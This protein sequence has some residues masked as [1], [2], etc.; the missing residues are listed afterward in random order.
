MHINFQT[1]VHPPVEKTEQQ[2]GNR[3]LN[4]YGA[5]KM[6][7][8]NPSGVVMDLD[9]NRTHGFKGISAD[10]KKD[11]ERG[12]IP[13][14]VMSYDAKN[15]H[16]YM[17]VMS[18]TMSAKDFQELK[19]EGYKPGKMSEAEAVTG[20]DRIKVILAQSGVDVAGF[21]D[22]LDKETVKEITG[23]YAGAEGL[24]GESTV[25]ELMSADEESLKD[26]VSKSLEE[27]DLPATEAN[28]KDALTALNMA[29][30]LEAPDS[31]STEYLLSNLKEPT[32]ENVYFAEHS[33]AGEGSGQAGG[34]FSSDGSA[35]YAEVA[36]NEDLEGLRDQI[37]SVLKRAGFEPDNRLRNDAEYLIRSGF[38]L[39][40][41]T[42]GLYEDIKGIAFPLKAGD[43]MAEISSAISGG[44]GAASAALIRGYNRIKSERILNETRLQMNTEAN[45]AIKTDSGFSLET[46]S[47]SEKVEELK[48]KEDAFYR[49]AFL[50]G[51][52]EG[53]MSLEDCISLAEETS[54]K[55]NEIKNMPAALAGSFA[56][57]E[58]F[59]VNDVYEAGNLMKAKFEEAGT[60][61]EAVGTE[62]R[63]DLG[64][65][66]GDAFR[67]AADLLKEL[68]IKDT[69]ENLRAVRILGYNGMEITGENIDSVKAADQTVRTL[70]NR[71][72]GS[73]VVSLIREGVNPLETSVQDLI[74]KISDMEN[75][76]EENEKF[77][78][79]LF[80]LERN[81]EISDEE[82]ESYIG[83]F[84]LIR[85]IEKSDGAVIGAVVNS[86]RE[87]S[88]RNLLTELRTRGRGHMDFSIDDDFGGVEASG[89]T[90][91]IGK[92][93]TQ[94]E[95]AFRKEPGERDNNESAGEDK[96]KESR[97]EE[98]V[99]YGEN[100]IHEIYDRLD[101]GA[102]KEMG[103]LSGDTT[104][105]ELINALRKGSL[106]EAQQEEM[107]SE[108]MLDE[109]REAASK[110]DEVYEALLRFG[111]EIT[112]ENV[113]AMDALMNSRGA[114]F[115][116]FAELF[117][118]N[119][120]DI[121][122]SAS[123]KILDRM[124]RDED[125]EEGDT[126]EE[127]REAYGEMAEEAASVLKEASE[128]ADSYIDLKRLHNLNRQLTVARALSNEENY[129]IPM[130]LDGKFTSVN[131]KII[132]GTGE[133]KA[134]VS[135]ESE[136]YGK[137]Y[138]E[139]TLENGSV[140]GFVTT[141]GDEGESP[142]RERTELFKQNLGN[143]GIDAGEII[144]EKSLKTDINR[145]PKIADK[146]TVDHR[147]RPSGTDGQENG[148][149]KDAGTDPVLLY[150]TAGI[151]I[152]SF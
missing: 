68:E 120:P 32:I 106:T 50:K 90:A 81:R 82:A 21:T 25:Q 6:S 8:M 60:L 4:A 140:N 89:E 69:I 45:R 132:R 56:S 30:D 112:P 150:K 116:A 55:V 114:L 80:K 28:V 18:N 14:D 144:F 37:D 75:L 117:A 101:P 79:Y 49:A 86:G 107:Y 61:Y 134:S 2:A 129:E 142:V 83:I 92:I 119:M 24:S 73:A 27:R 135:F 62:V 105:N 138:A 77:S 15:S 31:G 12:G 16:N 146:N 94:I 23:S 111:Q 11:K 63:P 72:T 143:R 91:G 78:E 10:R 3:A 48:V 133:S 26:F 33:G 136:R 109:I 121:M 35:Y 147:D 74:K 148:T 67:N 122:R 95:T 59:T 123:S 66:I 102:L 53:G 141:E 54:Y 29:A 87:L 19:E 93:D 139:F 22:T 38:A 96:D 128:A 36:G 130:E 43:L 110:E 137:V 9:G 70:I 71:L 13:E 1:E 88:L 40:E 145:I 124:D 7:G 97:P 51:R 99:Q 41:E 52:E 103:G 42:I 34:Y 151:F 65:R 76:S 17:A 108:E 126:G 58:E 85:Q 47:L 149:G 98:A 84:R 118:G 127:V 5:G 113:N 125:E 44:E 104:L 115:S 57:A 39:T 100:L 152:Q 64:D 46:S 20:L 131:L